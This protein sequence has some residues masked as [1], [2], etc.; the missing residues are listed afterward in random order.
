MA[1]AGETTSTTPSTDWLSP[2]E[3]QEGLSAYVET[4]RERFIVVIVNLLPVMA[5]AILYVLTAD[6]VYKPRPTCSSRQCCV[7][8]FRRRPGS[9]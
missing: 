5:G 6:D 1:A 3:D 7:R 4:L 2:P 9:P 8:R